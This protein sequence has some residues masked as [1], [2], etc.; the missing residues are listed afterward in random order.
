MP[1][2][3]LQVGVAQRGRARG[4]VACTNAAEHVR[5]PLHRR[6]VRAALGL[7]GV[8]QRRPARRRAPPASFQARLRGVARARREALAG[9]RRHQVRGVAGQQDAAA[10]PGRGHAR[11]ER[12]DDRALDRRGLAVEP[13][14]RPRA[15]SRPAR[16][17]A[18]RPRPGAASTPS[19]GGPG[20]IGSVTIGPLRVADEVRVRDLAQRAVDERVDDDPALRRGLAVERDLQ[21]GADRAVAA[22][23]ADEPAGRH[24]LGGPAVGRAQVERRRGRRAGRACR[25]S[26][27]AGPRRVGR[28]RERGE[29]RAL[30]RRLVDRDQRRVAEQPDPRAR[31]SRPRGR[32]R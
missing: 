3:A 26:A 12:V 6:D 17:A 5:Q 25:A 14:A 18:R 27:R 10:A 23:A 4:V 28:S 2:I 16:G 24:A 15:R 11:V 21:A 32:R 31:R 8:Q 9:E 22:V 7:V 30:H 13:L 19:G 29:H 20:D 1:S